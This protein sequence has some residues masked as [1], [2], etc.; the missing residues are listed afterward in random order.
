[1]AAIS[2]TYGYSMNKVQGVGLL[3]SNLLFG[4]TLSEASWKLQV[5]RQEPTKTKF[6]EP[7]ANTH[8]QF[9]ARKIYRL[10]S[11][12]SFIQTSRRTLDQSRES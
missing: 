2:L 9:W 4:F 5:S 10:G 1:M 8:I 6:L 7:A 11:S 12:D 3:S